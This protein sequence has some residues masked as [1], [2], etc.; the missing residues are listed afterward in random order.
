MIFNYKIDLITSEQTL[1]LRQ[2]I[3]KPFLSKKECVNP[4]D[5]LPTTTHFG[6]FYNDRLISIAT[7]F[8]ESNKGLFCGFPYRLRGMATDI[9]YQ[10][11]GF[12]GATLMAVIDFLKDKRCDLLWC[13][14]RFKAFPFY[15]SSGFQFH[16]EMFELPDIG[17]HKV[18]YKRIIGK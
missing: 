16:G 5:F 9:N 7:V 6:L 11:Q 8:P 17:P 4:E 10:G 1:D 18:M 12:G 3:L 13:N 14:A 15:K 2:K